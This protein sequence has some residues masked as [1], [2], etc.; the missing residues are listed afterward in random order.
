MHLQVLGA[1]WLRLVA[2]A[3]G[4]VK[5]LAQIHDLLEILLQKAREL[6]RAGLIVMT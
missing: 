5:R 1:F 6:V 4:N 3:G 2:L